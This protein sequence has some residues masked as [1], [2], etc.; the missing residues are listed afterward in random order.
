MIDSR[1]PEYIDLNFDG[2]KAWFK[3][4][5]ERGLLFHPDDS[6][7]EIITIQTGLPT[8]NLEECRELKV[9]VGEMFCRF[10]NHVYEAAYPVFMAEFRKKTKR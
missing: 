3:T 10:G 2:M 4:M 8:F 9:T 7:D 6:P 5:A 1:I